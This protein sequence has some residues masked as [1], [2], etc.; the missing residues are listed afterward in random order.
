MS[1]KLIALALALII[2]LTFSSC[3]NTSRKTTLNTDALK[4]FVENSKKNGEMS[5]DRT[6]KAYKGI[7]PKIKMK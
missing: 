3:S 6:K 7:F 5:Y 2:A 1:R 4:K